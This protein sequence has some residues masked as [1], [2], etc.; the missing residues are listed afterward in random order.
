MAFSKFPESRGFPLRG[1][2]NGRKRGAFI[3]RRKAA[4]PAPAN[5]AAR[6]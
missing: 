6:M 3:D 4:E 2:R 1:N 5:S